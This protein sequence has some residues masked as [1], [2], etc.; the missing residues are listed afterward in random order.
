MIRNL[1]R[2]GRWEGMKFGDIDSYYWLAKGLP[3][4]FELRFTLVNGK[5]ITHKVTN[6]AGN[7]FIN[8]KQSF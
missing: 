1:N 5:S 2:N 4:S 7:Q 6:P 8:T 3:E